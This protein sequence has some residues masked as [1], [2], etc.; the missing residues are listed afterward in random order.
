MQNA[1]I[2]TT[3]T[4]V[5]ENG[6]KLTLELKELSFVGFK[7]T[8]AW[9]LKYGVKIQSDDDDQVAYETTGLEYYPEEKRFNAHHAFNLR[10]G[11]E[12]PQRATGYSYALEDFMEK[13]NTDQE[14]FD[15]DSNFIGYL[16]EHAGKDFSFYFPKTIKPEA[17]IAAIKGIR[18]GYGGN[19]E[20]CFSKARVTP[21]PAFKLALGAANCKYI[22]LH[23]S[24]SENKTKVMIIFPRTIDHDRM[25]EV[26][27]DACYVSFKS[28]RGFNP[29][30]CHS[31]GFL[32]KEKGCHGSSETL[33]KE[34]N[35]AVDNT[36]FKETYLK[37]K[38]T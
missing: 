36:L 10:M 7:K 32:S 6:D 24:E 29:V 30:D 33:G 12:H 15:A 18:V 11:S 31:A 34:S 21:I 28:E 4:A 8:T 19:W 3:L 5:F 38:Q 2:A 35:P 27:Q 26:S 1:I 16:L 9:E 22:V 13:E 20:R 17:A 37:E 25:F 14:Q 23:D